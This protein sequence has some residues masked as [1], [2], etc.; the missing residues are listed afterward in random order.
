MSQYYILSDNELS[1]AGMFRQA[2]G[3]ALY[4]IQHHSRMILLVPS[5]C[6]HEDLY[7]ASN[8]SHNFSYDSVCI[9]TIQVK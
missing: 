5:F 6:K 4:R 2:L 3:G 1:F 9:F 8:I 7:L